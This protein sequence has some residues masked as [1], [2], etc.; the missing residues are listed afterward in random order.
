MAGSHSKFRI[1]HRRLEMVESL[2][3]LSSRPEN[4]IDK[5]CDSVKGA[6]DALHCLLVISEGNAR[7]LGWKTNNIAL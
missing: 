1:S 6:G 7:T 2:P 3:G 5:K 4:V